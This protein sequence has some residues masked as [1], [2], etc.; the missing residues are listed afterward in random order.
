MAKDYNWDLDPDDPYDDYRTSRRDHFGRFVVIAFVIAVILHL[1]AFFFLGKVPFFVESKDSWEWQSK[2]VNIEQPVIVLPNDQD[3]A[4]TDPVDEVTPPE[5]AADLLS[6]I[7]DILP[8]LRDT[9]IDI[10]PNIAEP[11][12]E[13]KLE[14]PAL[15]GE[16]LDDLLEPTKGPDV[17]MDLDQL[18][19]N[20]NLFKEA[21]EGQVT[22]DEGSSMADVLD[23]DEFNDS[24]L[25]KGAGGLDENGAMEGFSRLDDLLSMPEG[26]LARSKAMI[27]SDLL[28]EFGEATLRESARLSLMKVAMLVELNPNMYCWVE[29]HTDLLGDEAYNQELSRQRAQAVAT[30]LTKAFDVNPARLHVQAY[31]MSQPIVFEGDQIQQAVNRRVEIK[32]RKEKPPGADQQ[33]SGPVTRKAVLVE[34][35]QGQPVPRRAPQPAP[36]K[37]EPA[38]ALPVEQAPQNPS[39]KPAPPEALPAF[40]VAPDQSEEPAQALPFR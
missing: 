40:P 23:P 38:Q 17:S 35:S 31:G 2:N 7:D 20:D 4:L 32:M 24:L 13:L 34:D 1:I 15:A 11:E 26:K 30:Y 9:D 36:Q 33:R 14:R 27:G 5:N 6:K 21:A 18:G 39:P 16:G 3:E 22:I 25:K 29:G 19:Q 8:E 12:V 10:S 37:P 28:F